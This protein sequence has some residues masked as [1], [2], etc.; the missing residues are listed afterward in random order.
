MT[1]GAGKASGRQLRAESTASLGAGVQ[2]ARG[3]EESGRRT[4]QAQSRP[5]EFEEQGKLKRT[6]SKK[7]T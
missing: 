4:E 1:V 6:E 2:Q 7:G 5:A 3:E